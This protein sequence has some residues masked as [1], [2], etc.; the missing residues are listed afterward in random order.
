[1]DTIEMQALTR[2]ELCPRLP[3]ADQMWQN[4]VVIAL[5]RSRP[6]CLLPG[7]QSRINTDRL[8]LGQRLQDKFKQRTTCLTHLSVKFLGKD[9]PKHSCLQ[10][11]LK[12]YR[13]IRP[14]STYLADKTHDRTNLQS[15]RLVSAISMQ[16]CPPFPK[17]LLTL[18]LELNAK[19]T[20][21]K[22]SE[23]AWGGVYNCDT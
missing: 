10:G 20:S 11:S 17:I 13:L 12:T 2:P 6:R 7:V 9:W 16:S 22:S 8:R 3:T 4:K 15:I 14:D 23:Y 5:G 1:M 21:R 19:A 18:S